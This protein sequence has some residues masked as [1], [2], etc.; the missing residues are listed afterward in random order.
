[1]CGGMVFGRSLRTRGDANR[2]KLT[3]SWRAPSVMLD[4]ASGGVLWPASGQSRIQPQCK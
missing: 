3:P 2:G 4:L 1:M